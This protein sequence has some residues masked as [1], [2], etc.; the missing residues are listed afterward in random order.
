[1]CLNIL[2]LLIY[3]KPKLDLRGTGSTI[4]ITQFKYMHIRSFQLTFEPKNSLNADIQ[5]NYMELAICI[6]TLSERMKQLM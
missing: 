2:N 6:L 3:L 4:G 5:L 1:M